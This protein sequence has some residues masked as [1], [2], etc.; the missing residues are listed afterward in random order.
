LNAALSP[1]SGI[2]PGGTLTP[3]TKGEKRS[4]VT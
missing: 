1:L 3:A 2:V 4:G